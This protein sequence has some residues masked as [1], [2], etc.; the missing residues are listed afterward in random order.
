M[1]EIWKHAKC[2][3][4][5]PLRSR[6]YLVM[7]REDHNGYTSIDQEYFDEASQSSG[8]TSTR[9]ILLLLLEYH[10]CSITLLKDTRIKLHLLD[11]LGI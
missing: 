11:N 10:D 2:R 3:T 5:E 1:E 9:A 4:T 6:L 7:N 8:M